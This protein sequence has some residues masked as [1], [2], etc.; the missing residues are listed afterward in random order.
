MLTYDYKGK[1]VLVSGA[2]SGIGRAIAEAF[3]A[4]GASVAVA[5]IAPA[6]AEATA[7]GIA[8]AG[9]TAR[10]FTVDVADEAAAAALVADIVAAFGRLD[11]AINNAG[12]EAANLPLAELDSAIWR[13]VSDVNLSA[14]FYAMKAQIPQMLTQGGGAIVNTASIS[15]LIGGYNLA[16]YT[17]TKHGVIGMTKAAAMDYADTDFT[18]QGGIRINALCPGL[19]DT[20]FIAQLPPGLRKRL[21]DGIP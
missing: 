3:G 12:I 2:G 13:R 10:A 9:G 21:I 20:P 14:V 8:A 6:S 11:C 19:V 4:A 17:A 16:A 7:A 1:V 5:D 18:G 15:G